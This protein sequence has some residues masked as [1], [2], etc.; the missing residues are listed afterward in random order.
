[1]NSQEL[2]MPCHANHAVQNPPGKP[3]LTL[4]WDVYQIPESDVKTITLAIYSVNIHTLYGKSC[5]T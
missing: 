2:S 4:V 3:A 5:V 1:M